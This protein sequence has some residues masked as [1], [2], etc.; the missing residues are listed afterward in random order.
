MNVGVNEDPRRLINLTDSF[1]T[2]SGLLPTSDCAN[3][4]LDS[5]VLFT[6][7]F[8]AEMFLFLVLKV[9]VLSLVLQIERSFNWKKNEVPPRRRGVIIGPGDMPA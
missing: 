6:Y 5:F 3:S 7:A 8:I 1:G 4:A 9:R 2:A